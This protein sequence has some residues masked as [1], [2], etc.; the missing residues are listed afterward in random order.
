MPVKRRI[1][2]RNSMKEI[3]A[4]GTVF[5]TGHDFF[6]E[7]FLLTGVPQPVRLPLEDRIRGEAEWN[8]MARQA[9]QSLGGQWLASYER[10]KTPWA[11]EKFGDPA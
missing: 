3:E 9:W 5:E 6:Q 1:S 8:E 2:K 10:D 7:V 4:W 11:I